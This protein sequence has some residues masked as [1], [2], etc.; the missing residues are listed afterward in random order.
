V[1]P[2]RR[3][4]RFAL[5]AAL[6]ALAV[7]A[8]SL[9][10]AELVESDPADGTTITTPY[11]FRAEYSEDLGGNSRIIVH[12]A[13]GNEVARGGISDDDPRV[14]TVELEALPAGDYVALWRAVTPSDNGVTRGTIEF[15]VGA[16]ATPSPTPATAPPTT[17]TDAPSTPST[18]PATSPSPT[19]GLTASPSPTPTGGQPA[20]ATGDLLMALLIAGALLGG[21]VFFLWRRRAA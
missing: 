17:R 10:H 11:T 8:V 18:S 19:A 14:M 5:L 9:A 16:A 7:P 1:I 2:L 21:L 12:D 4:L 13:S 3:P 6:M 20:G 15:R